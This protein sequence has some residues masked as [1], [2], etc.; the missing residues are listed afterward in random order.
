MRIVSLESDLRN[1]LSEFESKE[2]HFQAQV[3]SLLA[4][5]RYLQQKLDSIESAYGSGDNSQSNDAEIKFEWSHEEMN[6]PQEELLSRIHVLES[7]NRSLEC[8]LEY[9]ENADRQTDNMMDKPEDIL[10][11]RIMDLEKLEKHLK[12][13]VRLKLF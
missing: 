11:Q 2:K 5:E 8:R 6:A 13:Q 1:R 10:R 7:N 12:T 4:S 3:D 9:F